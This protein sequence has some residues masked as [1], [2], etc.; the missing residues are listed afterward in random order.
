MMI[1]W[2]ELHTGV[3]R[4]RTGAPTPF[5]PLG[6]V[7]AQPREAALD[8]L[9]SAPFPFTGPKPT[10]IAA[11]GATTAL[12]FPMEPDERIY[13][14]GLHFKRLNH[15]GSVMRLQVDHYGGRDDGR[16]HASMP[17]YVSSAGYAVLVNTALVATAD[18]GTSVRK[19]DANRP[20]SRDRNADNAWEALPLADSV[21]IAVP[22]AGAE[23]YVFAGP[24]AMDAVRRYNLFSGGGTLPPRWALGFWHRVPTLYTD[25]QVAAEVEEFE[26]RGYPLDVVG[27]EPGW[28][29]KAYPCTYEWDRSRFPDPAA[30][31]NRMAERELRV[32][33]WENAYVSPDAPVHDALEPLSGSHM[34]WG[35]IVPDYTLPEAREILAG[36]HKR[37]HVDIGVSG[38]KLDECD[39]H[40]H[41]LWPAHATFP[42]GHTGE[43]M[44]QT[45]GLQ[46]QSLTEGVFRD[47]DRRTFGLTRA[48][49][50]GAA[51]LPYALYSDYYDHRAFVTALCNSGFSGLLWSPEIRN[52]AGAEEWA[53]R[54]QTVCFSPVAMLNAWASGTKPWS[55]PEIDDAI[56]DVM[57][58][59]I[60][61]VPYIYSAFARYHFEGTPPFRST[62]LEEG[63]VSDRSDQYMMGDSLLVAPLFVGETEREV[64]FPA[65]SWFD[66]YTGEFVKN[67]GDAGTHTVSAPLERIPLFV[68][69]GGVIPLQREDGSGLDLRFYGTAPHGSFRYYL[70]DGETYA[71]ERGEYAWA[72]LDAT[73]DGESLDG[74][75]IIPLDAGTEELRDATWHMMTP[76]V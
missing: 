1:D 44:R 73:R 47:A 31:V 68:R 62:V 26:E 30:F 50:I 22:A 39:G 18:V 5:T 54:M 40:D 11:T 7:G 27:L 13:G 14:F 72:Q 3:W 61:L 75:I 24:T 9:G 28:H 2:L 43:E 76:R 55:Y 33:L 42:S 37:A 20:P 64:E 66:F 15:R 70:D 57:R 34:V 10:V 19:D 21:E 71:Y 58:L 60:Q 29:S 38:Y 51:P 46:L 8:A 32:N 16:S 4:A 53:R 49:H 56:R 65:G 52:A 67:V 17:Y 45:Y 23:V 6:V 12:R 35:G 69:D 63:A 59:R 74:S 48:S 25:E 36:Q 41:W